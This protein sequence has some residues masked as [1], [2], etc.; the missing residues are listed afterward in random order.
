MKEQFQHEESQ[1]PMTPTMQWGQLR[2]VAQA[3]LDSV[4]QS[5]VDVTLQSLWELAY[6]W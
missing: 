5:M 1:H 2:Y 3:S 4:D 6:N